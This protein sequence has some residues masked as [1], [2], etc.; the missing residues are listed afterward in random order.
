MAKTPGIG[1]TNAGNGITLPVATSIVGGALAVLASLDDLEA[2][3]A[4][5]HAAVDEAKARVK[6]LP[7]DVSKKAPL[8]RGSLGTRSATLKNFGVKKVGSGGGRKKGGKPAKA[9]KTTPK[10]TT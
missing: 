1:P 5:Y 3:Q 8:L 2:K 9:P 7:D 4:A 6:S 10:S